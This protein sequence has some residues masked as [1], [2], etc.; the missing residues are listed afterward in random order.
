M[1][2]AVVLSVVLGVLCTLVAPPEAVAADPASG[3]GT[4]IHPVEAPVVADF[5]PPLTTYGPGT[6]GL[7]YGTEPGDEIRAAGP[8][9]VRFAGQAG[10]ALHVTVEHPDGLLTSYSGVGEI[11]VGLHDEVARGQVVA[12]ADGILH[13]GVRRDGAYIDPAAV[14]GVETVEVRLV[15]ELPLDRHSWRTPGLE[16]AEMAWLARLELDGGGSR[17]GFLGSAWSAVGS[18]GRALA[19]STLEVIAAV[20]PTVIDALW[21]LAPIVVAAVAGPIVAAL[22]FNLAI[23]L[24]RGE[25]PP[26]LQLLIDLNPLTRIDRIVRR[27]L[28]WWEH[29]SNCTP[30]DQA[31]E[32]S[33]ERRVAVLVA[34]YDSNSEGSSIGGLRTD[35]LAYDDA[36]VIGFSYAGGRTPGRF[37]D[38]PDPVADDL[39]TIPATTY[40]REHSTTDL[41][42]RGELLAD[43]LTDVHATSPGTPIDVYAH[44]QGGIVTRLALVELASRPGGGEVIASLGLV[45]TL[46]SPHGGADLATWAVLAQDGDWR[47]DLGLW[48]VDQVV[49]TPL[50]PSTSTVSDLARGSELLRGLDSAGLP[51]GPT[52]LSLGAR[53]DWL[54][55]DERA[56]LGEGHHVTVPV[57]GLNAHSTMTTHP[58]TTRE[59]ALARAGDPPTCQGVGSFL[60]DMASGEALHTLSVGLG[61]GLATLQML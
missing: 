12:I 51:D 41:Q 24:L 20:T 29:R 28:E 25:R 22:V 32:S 60:V 44:S 48:S 59:L 53:L 2:R 1:L 5:D 6:R 46:G 37:S 58:S 47:S 30:D 8:G 16:A 61:A 57:G 31:P 40:G 33:E 23:P 49:G 4:Y 7:K 38:G 45:A 10:G 15:P 36:D 19:A 42:R 11:R 17:W 39:A 18:V 26:L 35:D 43:L 27:T 9:R 52:Y 34:G 55:L 14:F 56:R 3:P 54:V 21:V 13:V 50:H